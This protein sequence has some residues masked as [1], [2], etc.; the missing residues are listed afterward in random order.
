ME[1]FAYAATILSIVAATVWPFA[2]E[3]TSMRKDIPAEAR[4]ITLTGVAASGTWTTEDVNGG[5]YWNKTFPAAHVVLKA[6]ETVAF[7]FKSPDVVH[8]FYSPELGI[9]PV[10]VYPG[11]V[12]KVVVTPKKTGVF[13]YYC[14][15]FCGDPHF[16][17]R[18]QIEVRG[19]GQPAPPT[20]AADA[21]EYWR[22][23]EPPGSAGMA[24]RGKW[25]FHRRGCVTCHGEGGKGGI[26][27]FNY[28]RGTVPALN[29]I[30]ERMM[31]DDPQ[32]ARAVVAAMERG[33][34]LESLEGSPPV[35]K[36]NVVLAQYHS[37]R[38]VIRGGSLS[39]KLDPGGPEPPLQMPAWRARLSDRDIDSVIAYFLTLQPEGETP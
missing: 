39:A 2:H 6:G 3:A 16:G 12:A 10:E 13:Q 7:R 4:V 14:T 38:D 32:D 22:A 15:T 28:A 19:D 36:F 30:S 18:G 11:H 27:N 34:T 31:L 23:A 5:N 20:A 9:G 29:A 37:V 33:A 26:A 25:I 1:V 24:E 17:M 35:P 21:G 8:T